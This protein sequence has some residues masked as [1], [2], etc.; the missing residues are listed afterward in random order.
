MHD[1]GKIKV[2]DYVLQKPGKLTE[3]EFEIMKKH[4]ADGGEIIRSTMQ[5]I[6]EADYM[7]VAYNVA[8][9]HHEKWNGMGYPTGMGGEVIPL[10]AR[11]MAVADVF[12]ALISKRCYKEAMPVDKA[13]SIIEESAGSH[14]DPQIVK[15]FLDLRPQIEASL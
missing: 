12:D 4:A 6:E 14:F 9:Y 3:D 5:N 1:I 8:T 13:F 15:V 2:P 11:I 10:E 7:Q